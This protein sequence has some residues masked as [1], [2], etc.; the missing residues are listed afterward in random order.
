[1]RAEPARA[2]ADAGS[3]ASL[4]STALSAPIPDP[5]I[6]EQNA[7]HDLAIQFGADPTELAKEA[8]ELLRQGV[9]LE[10]FNPAGLTPLGFAIAC[11]QPELALA[12]LRSGANP[13]PK[14]NVFSP[15]CLAL[16]HGFEELA[17]ELA[18]SGA[19]AAEGPFCWG[20]V[21]PPFAKNALAALA[22]LQE[23]QALA[24]SL[25]GEL[26]LSPHRPSL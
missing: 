21:I 26:P 17:I 13:S 11:K 15:L 1:M 2:M 25:N 20:G 8:I 7:L 24:E 10:A 9:E 18:K 12:L 4:N 6:G 5:F 23:R 3:D 19:D 16:T 22:R 14:S